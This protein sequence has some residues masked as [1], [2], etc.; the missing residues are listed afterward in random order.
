MSGCIKTN[1]G[2]SLSNSTLMELLIQELKET[3]PSRTSDLI[4]WLFAELLYDQETRGRDNRESL[5]MFLRE[6]NDEAYHKY[7]IVG[8]EH[9][10]D[11]TEREEREWADWLE[12]REEFLAYKKDAK[13][14]NYKMIGDENDPR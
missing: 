11:Q 5:E 13:V 1:T 4:E 14:P 9:V 12:H 7:V 2:F 8:E 6:I 10:S 3:K